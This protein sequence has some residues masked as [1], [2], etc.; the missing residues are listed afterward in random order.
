MNCGDDGRGMVHTTSMY[1]SMDLHIIWIQLSECIPQTSNIVN[2]LNGGESVLKRLV[3][4]W[5]QSGKRM[6]IT[7]CMFNVSNII[8]INGLNGWIS[9]ITILV[10]SFYTHSS[11]RVA[12]TFLGALAMIVQVMFHV[13][14]QYTY[15]EWLSNTQN[16]N[17]C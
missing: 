13:R 16:H 9:L 2:Y 1:M 12:T 3:S 14:F 4:L 6:L 17:N 10:L 8:I 5:N 15:F 7:I 11:C